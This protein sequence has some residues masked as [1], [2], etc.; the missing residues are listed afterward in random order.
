MAP[1]S[2]PPDDVKARLRQLPKVDRL[3]GRPEVEALTARLGPRLVK[4]LVQDLL[5]R[6]REEV[7]EQGGEAPAEDALVVA[8]VAA[9]R[10]LLNRRARRVINATGVVLHTNLGR[11][12]L[13]RRAVDAI[14][15][16]AGG[17][18]SIELDLVTGRRGARGAFMEIA[19][20]QLTGAEAALVVNN[21]AAAVLLVLNELAAGRG[22][23]VSRGEQVEIGGGFRVPEVLARSGAKMIEV[24]TTNRTR[25]RDYARAIDEHDDV[26]VLLRVHRSNF[27]QVGFVEEPPLEELSALAK[28]RGLLLVH[29]LGGGA[30]VDPA[31]VGLM[32]EPVVQDCVGKGADVVC[33]SADKLLGGPQ[34]GVVVGRAELVERIRKNPL[35]RALRLGRLP[36]V[37]LEATLE[38]YLA[39]EVDAIPAQ[40]AMRRV[41][42]AVRERVTRWREDL[43]A[44]GVAAE[45]VQVGAQIGGGTLAEIA[46]A[47]W[48]LAFDPPDVDGVAQ[49]LRQGEPAV[50]ARI[51]AGRLLVDGRTVLDDEQGPLLQAL[52]AALRA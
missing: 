20:A 51:Q 37:A 23:V 13:S 52:T 30:L 33:F 47:S 32:G 35:Q 11:A 48:A 12:P 28:E 1:P 8:T 2:A 7:R 29:D 46:L 27:R 38:S 18:S 9:G 26:A 43:A 41:P 6:A 22:V 16:T 21:C 10:Q 49:Q 39:G 19:L 24:G 42:E 17:Y 36:L 14:A 3:L 44:R 25:T 31:E 5:Q 40:A 45:V 4:G 50:M 34:G 15:A